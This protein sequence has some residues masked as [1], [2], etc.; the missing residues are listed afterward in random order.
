M[1]GSATGAAAQQI[2]PFGG[3]VTSPSSSG[4]GGGSVERPST[5]PAPRPAAPTAFQPASG[6]NVFQQSASALQQAQQAAGNLADFQASPMQAAKLAPTATY[7]GANIGRASTMR[8]VGQVG[9]INAPGQI[10]VNQI[11]STDLGAYMN[12]YIQSVVELGQQDIERQRQMASNQLGAQAQSAGAFGGSRQAV[13]EA[14]LA[15]EAMRQAGQLSAQQRQAGFQQALQSSQFDINQLQAAR[16]MASQQQM[17]AR[18]LNQQAAEAAAQREQAARAGNMQAANQFAQLQAQLEQQ[19]GLSNQAAINAARQQQAQFQQAANQ[20]TFGGQF[21]GAGIRA[22]AASQLG[23]LA[24]TGFGMGQSI[25]QQQ[26]QQGAMQQALQ[27][28]LIDAARNQYLGFTGAPLQSLGLPLQALG[29]S[30]VP[31]TQTSSRQPGLFDYLTTFATAASGFSDP[32]L[33]TNVQPK[34][35]FRGVKFYTWDWNETAKGIVDPKQPTFGVMA[36]ELQKTH[37]HLVSKGE[38]GYLR[39]NYAQLSKELAEAA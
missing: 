36:D 22:N 29:V 5:Q 4:K 8:G 23:G 14:Q 27:Q 35:E 21:Q 6:Q 9:N 7:G 39:V 25:Q 26:V 13:Q 15:S 24:Q 11:A 30:P 31:Q 38:D 2:S 10:A 33:K 3:Q 17:Q 12:P 19:A 20:A 1:A 16:S 18:T 37:P 28:Q 34:G 32:R